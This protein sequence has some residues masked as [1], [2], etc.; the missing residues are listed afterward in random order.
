[1]IKFQIPLVHIIRNSFDHGIEDAE[2]R[3][4]MGKTEI[5]NIS[6]N[7]EYVGNEIWINV[8]DD[9]AGL[10]RELIINKA[11]KMGLIKTDPEA[12]KNEDVW[13]IIFEPGFTTSERVSEISGRGVGMDVVLKN[14]NNL[15]GKVDIQTETGKG[16][17]IILKIPLKI[18]L[19]EGMNVKVGQKFYTILT[20]DILEFFKAKA[21][22]IIQT[23]NG[24]EVLKH[25]GE[26]IPVIK[27]F[28]LFDIKTNIRKLTDGIMILIYIGG[29]KACLLID[30]I[31]DKQVSV[32]KTNY[33]NDQFK[34]FS[35]YN[36]LE[37]GEVSFII[38]GE[39]LLKLSQG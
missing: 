39:T 9:G 8:K 36:V 27:L 3:K 28:D 11:L 26:I 34:V 21:K 1:M 19:V 5:G 7:A 16:T 24:K 37:N 18:A 31:I 14:I 30:K 12:I 6:L 13:K 2:A 15:H 22:Q 10:N 33:F 35:G 20:S 25:R 29:K 32:V 4:R 23:S 17:E 38:D